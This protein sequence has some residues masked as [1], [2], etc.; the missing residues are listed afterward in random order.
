MKAIKLKRILIRSISKIE[1]ISFLKAIN[2]ILGS[3]T[4]NETLIL[5]VAQLNEI[6]VSKKEIEQGL[7]VEHVDFNKEITLWLKD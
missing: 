6:I 4:N 3:T 5:S 1:D 2:T 7:F